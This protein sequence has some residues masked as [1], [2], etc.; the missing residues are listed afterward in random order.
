[1]C[2]SREQRITIRFANQR[3]VHFDHSECPRCQ[4]SSGQSEKPALCQPK[5]TWPVDMS[6]LFVTFSRKRIHQDQREEV[7]DHVLF[8]SISRFCVAKI[9]ASYSYYSI[10]SCREYWPCLDQFEFWRWIAYP[11]EVYNRPQN[12]SFRS[13]QIKQKSMTNI[14]DLMAANSMLFPY[15]LVDLVV[16]RET[17]ILIWTDAQHEKP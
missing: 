1:M 10:F 14:V 8:W 12:G 6:Y 3:K 16:Y 5:K 13:H 2:R 9:V 15:T 4:W 7:R 11:D 17:E